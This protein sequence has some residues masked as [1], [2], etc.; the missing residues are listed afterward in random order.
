MALSLILRNAARTNGMSSIIK[1]TII[2]DSRKTFS[3]LLDKSK[4]ISPLYRK[5]NLPIVKR[6][7]SGDH[8]KLWPIEKAVSVILLGV[9]PATFLTPNVVLDDMFAVLTVVHFHWGLEACVVDYIRPILFGAALPKISLGLLYL[10]SAATLGGLLYYN[11][12]CGGI[13]QTVRQF[14]EIKK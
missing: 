12:H 7:M 5:I 13:G 9:V 4:V 3:Q 10:I 8:S 6:S 1:S 11:H 14:W 2:V